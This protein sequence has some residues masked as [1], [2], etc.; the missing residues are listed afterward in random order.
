MSLKSQPEHQILT[1]LQ[2]QGIPTSPHTD[3]GH[4]CLPDLI[5]AYQ[6]GQV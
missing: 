6:T 3:L 2:R 4:L 1:E 5:H